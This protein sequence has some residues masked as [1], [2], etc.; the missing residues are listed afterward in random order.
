MLLSDS[1]FQ[2]HN[3]VVLVSKGLS[4]WIVGFFLIF[5]FYLEPPEKLTEAL[6]KRDLTDEHFFTLKHGESKL[7]DTQ[8]EDS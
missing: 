5:Q 2:P 1:N 3:N 4:F 7:I 6:E 8:S